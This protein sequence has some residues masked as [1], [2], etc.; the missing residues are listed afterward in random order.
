MQER[1]LLVLSL[2]ASLLL[3]LL[4][5]HCQVIPPVCLR[6]S[7]DI[8]EVSMNGRHPSLLCSSAG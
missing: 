2:S 8:A 3:V 7:E 4:T 1:V 5:T 6:R